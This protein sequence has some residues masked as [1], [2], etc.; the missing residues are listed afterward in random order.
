MAV[1]GSNP[2]WRTGEDNHNARLSNAHARAARFLRAEYH[3]RVED[4]A[5]MYRVSKAAMSNVLCGK[6]YPEAGGPLTPK[7]KSPG[8]WQGKRRPHRRTC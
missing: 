6:T 7:R 8:T 4:L 2:A 3:M 1:S 5:L